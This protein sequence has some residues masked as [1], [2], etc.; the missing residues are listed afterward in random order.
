MFKKHTLLN[1]VVVAALLTFPA[2]AFASSPHDPQTEGSDIEAQ[3]TVPFNH[4]AVNVGDEFDLSLTLTNH[5]PDDAVYNEENDLPIGEFLLPPSVTID[6]VTSI[7]EP[8][9]HCVSMAL[10]GITT[11]AISDA[12][13]GYNLAMCGFD[14]TSLPDGN[15]TFSA[16]ASLHFAA[17][18]TVNAPIGEETKF[19]GLGLSTTDPDFSDL[20]VMMG[21]NE[22]PFTELAD[23]NLISTVYYTSEEETTT[24]TTTTA[25]VESVTD[26]VASASFSSDDP[27][28]NGDDVHVTYTITNNGPDTFTVNGTDGVI[29]IFVPST[30]QLD[31]ASGPEG[32][33]CQTAPVSTLGDFLP[34]VLLSDLPDYSLAFCQHIDGPATTVVN[35][36]SLQFTFDGT[37]QTDLDSNSDP[38]Y[39]VGIGDTD[40]DISRL[41][42]AVANNQDPLFLDGLNNIFVLHFPASA[43]GVTTTTQ[44]PNVTTT[45]KAV[46]Q[47]KGDEI[48][49]ATHAL[50]DLAKTGA[51]LVT[52]WYGALA[53]LAGGVVLAVASKRRLSKSSRS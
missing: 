26:L 24:T 40:P 18:V 32:F 12:F 23:R 52:T 33:S 21:N 4:S 39:G 36:A 34:S 7:D 11:P 25:P 41:G 16:N 15:Y 44:S 53:L 6:S 38:I 10:E 28:K 14:Y 35:G 42:D 13:P 27:I 20:S 22:N 9:L 50:G 30:I 45:T 5:G 47:V 17:H 19:L 2:A 49:N 3:L 48:T 1:V 51:D 43:S 29:E 46:A 31:A 37:A 8:T